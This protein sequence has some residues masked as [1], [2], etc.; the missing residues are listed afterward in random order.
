MKFEARLVLEI[1]PD[2]N[3]LEVSKDNACVVVLE[4]LDDLIYD[5]DDIILTNCEVNTY[6]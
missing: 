1:H 2:A 6:D 3:F 4:L 5:T